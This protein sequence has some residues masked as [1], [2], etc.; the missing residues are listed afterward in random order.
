MEQRQ[1][2]I[3]MEAIDEALLPDYVGVIRVH[4]LSIFVP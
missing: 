4:L 3:E 1:N 2:N